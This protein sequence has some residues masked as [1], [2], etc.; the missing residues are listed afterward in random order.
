MEELTP[1]GRRLPRAVFVLVAGIALAA[2]QAH[3]GDFATVCATVDLS[4]ETAEQDVLPSRPS[5]GVAF[6][7]GGSRSAA[8]TLGQ[9]RGLHRTGLIQRVRYISAVSGGAWAAVPYTY[10][11]DRKNA[12][13]S[14]LGEAL[15]VAPEDFTDATLRLR[16]ED[17]ALASVLDGV[18]AFYFRF[19]SA[20]VSGRGNEIWSD[21]IGKEILEPFDLDDRETAFGLYGEHLD[22]KDARPCEMMFVEREPPAPYLII[23]GTVR[24]GARG[25]EEL[26]PFEITP[27][28]TGIPPIREV[29]GCPAPGYIES[30]AFDNRP[31]GC[32]RCGD[33]RQSF[34]IEREK[35]LFTLSDVLGITSSAPGLVMGKFSGFQTADMRVAGG[36]NEYRGFKVRD[37]GGFD[38]LG[39]IPLLL[40]EVE[41]IT[42]FVN[43]GFAIPNC[44]E[45]HEGRWKDGMLQ[46]FDPDLRTGVF[47]PADGRRL[48]SELLDKRNKEEVAFYCG[49][50]P[51]R[52]GNQLGIPVYSPR[53]C[54]VYLDATAW[55]KQLPCHGQRLVRRLK[56]G[57]RS[58]FR[59]FPHYRTFR[60]EGSWWQEGDLDIQEINALSQLTTWTVEQ[61]KDQLLSHGRRA[62]MNDRGQQ[63]EAIPRGENI[64]PEVLCR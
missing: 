44:R 16:Q 40:R 2:E 12:L 6:S 57:S 1:G 28:Y 26:L 43:S 45:C 17:V 22:P 29:P 38:N 56:D 62:D 13:A 39:V 15:F 14:F 42:L 8:A 52:E 47:Q 55:K 41:E 46:Y 63:D 23:G 25:R 5:Y 51:I 48:T 50:F 20:L 61:V 24:C 37:G 49:E 4:R 59:T 19:P 33:G 34:R 53:I 27:L 58:P 18:G 35:D 3:S 31:G 11:R 60:A 36:G 21:I 10:L 64:D 32:A 7:G 30:Y 9:L 54:W